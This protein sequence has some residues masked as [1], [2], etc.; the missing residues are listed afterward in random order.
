MLLCTEASS[1][2]YIHS[3]ISWIFRHRNS[4]TI[5]IQLAA[6]ICILSLPLPKT[7]GDISNRVKSTSGGSDTTTN[8]SAELLVRK[9]FSSSNRYEQS[10]YHTKYLPI[11][12]LFQ[13]R[14]L[15]LTLYYSKA[16]R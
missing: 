2:C 14:C 1:L 7:F 8:S 4:D 6:L 10:G 15:N 5:V 13:N 3:L 9:G 12:V 16:V 11:V